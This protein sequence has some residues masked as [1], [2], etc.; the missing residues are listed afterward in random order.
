MLGMSPP[1]Y[2]SRSYR[3][4]AVREP[5][6]LLQEFGLTLPPHVSINVHDSTADL[7]YMIASLHYVSLCV[8][9]CM[10]TCLT[11]HPFLYPLSPFPSTRV[12]LCMCCVCLC[13]CL[14]ACVFVCVCI[15]VCEHTCEGLQAL[16]Y[17]GG[18]VRAR[19]GSDDKFVI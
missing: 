8:R 5:R 14:C 6:P 9:L 11:F 13:M 12:S 17:K 3:A 19:M 1:W 7:R 2:K 4:R 16:P 18:P 10:S 15:C